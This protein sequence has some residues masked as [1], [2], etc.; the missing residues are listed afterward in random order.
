MAMYWKN[1]VKN[2]IRCL[3]CPH[4]CLLLPDKVGFCGVRRNQNGCLESLIDGKV[5]SVAIDP[6]EK[7]PLYHFYPSSKILSVGTFGC[8]FSCLF[9]QN[10]SIS[11]NT[12]NFSK[13]CKDMTPEEIC[14]IAVQYKEDG[15]I[16]I[17]YTYNEPSVWYEFVYKTSKY[18]NECGLKNVLVTNGFLNQ[19]PLKELMP[20]I[21]A[22]NVDI[23]SISPLFYKQYCK[24]TL[25]KV[26]EYCKTAIKYCH[27]EITNLV[28]PSLNDSKED[29]LKLSK[30]IYKY[31]GKNTP[32]HLSAYRPEFKMN[33]SATPLDT[34]EMARDTATKFLS[35]VYIGNVRS[36]DGANTVCP[37]CSHL[38]IKRR[39]FQII[40][41][42]IK[43]RRCPKCNEIL[44]CFMK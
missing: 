35:H 10:H 21:S 12:S 9:C 37:S 14:R 36:E 44:N 30:W 41:D 34:L 26:L 5:A 8:N 42:H 6:I 4:K 7:K 2:K 19:E 33:I 1:T 22:V 13:N 39:G 31:L 38:L 15:N 23:K 3:L 20:F 16:G 27:V 43:D 11:Q 24:G 18:A 28:I 29:I 17:A 25:K 32:L 40:E